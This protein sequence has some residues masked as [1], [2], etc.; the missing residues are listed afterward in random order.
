MQAPVTN[1]MRDLEVFKINTKA[2]G[3]GRTVESVV[4]DLNKLPWFKETLLLCE[5]ESE[6]LVLSA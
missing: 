3:T 6:G 2:Y 1:T 5:G 4:L